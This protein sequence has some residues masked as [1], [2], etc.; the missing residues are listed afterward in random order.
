MLSD[1][2]ILDWSN[3]WNLI[4]HI[5]LLNLSSLIFQR[6]VFV[7]KIEL[8]ISPFKWVK[9]QPSSMFVF[10]EIKQKLRRKFSEVFL[11][12]PLGLVLAI[13]IEKASCTFAQT[14]HTQ[15]YTENAWPLTGYIGGDHNAPL[16]PKSWSNT[17]HQNC[18]TSPYLLSGWVRWSVSEYFKNKW[19]ECLSCLQLSCHT[20]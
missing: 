17:P 4:S 2:K 8:R 18:L 11:W 9:S 14:R 13:L 15:L 12:H 5:V 6:K 19:K 20:L 1:L 10:R 3:S 7:L 16:V